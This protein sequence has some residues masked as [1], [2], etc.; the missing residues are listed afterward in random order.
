MEKK[1][2]SLNV[3][4]STRDLVKIIIAL[5]KIPIYVWVDEKA[6]QD[7]VFLQKKHEGRLEGIIEVKK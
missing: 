6:Q 1:K 5:R 4:P 2:V 3:D 7:W